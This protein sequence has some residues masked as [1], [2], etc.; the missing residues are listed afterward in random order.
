MYIY[1]ML[2]MTCSNMLHIVLHNMIIKKVDL[3]IEI[4]TFLSAFFFFFLVLAEND[5]H[6]KTTM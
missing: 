5:F 6:L 2:P 3:N 4:E 1:V